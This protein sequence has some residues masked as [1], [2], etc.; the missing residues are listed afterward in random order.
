MNQEF[1]DLGKLARK[2]TRDAALTV[3]QLLDDDGEKAALLASVAIDFI[4]G[5]AVMLHD[6]DCTEEEA[7]GEILK[8]VLGSLGAEVV[9]GAL[10]AKERK[11]CSG[12]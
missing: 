1:R 5:A 11:Q 12:D 10:T 7:L 9:I 4:R 8:M 3:T 2:R 6:N